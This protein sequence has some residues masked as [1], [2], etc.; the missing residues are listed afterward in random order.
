[1]TG[2]EDGV[3]YEEQGVKAGCILG[4]ASYHHEC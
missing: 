4:V 3:G 1:M 2:Q